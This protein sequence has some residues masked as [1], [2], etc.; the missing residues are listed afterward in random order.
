MVDRLLKAGNLVAPFRDAV[1]SS[2]AHFLIVSPAARTRSAVRALE[3]WLLAQA[4]RGH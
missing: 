1:A 2:R 3:T 4:S